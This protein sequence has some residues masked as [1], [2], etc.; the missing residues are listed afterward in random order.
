MKQKEILKQL[1][2]YNTIKDK[3][4]KE[5][6][7][8]IENYLKT[9]NFT[10]KRIKKCLIAYNDKNPK[11]GFIGHTDTV[12]Y[13]SW[14]GNPFE[15]QEK[16]DILIGLGACDMKG[17]IA[18]IL[19]A[20]SKIDLNKNKI[21]LYFTNDEEIAFEGINTIK[22]NIIPNNV[23]IGEP[24]NN[25]P[26][27]GTKGILELEITFY[28]KKCHSST[29]D[30]GI[31]AIYECIDFINK[32]KKYYEKNIKKEIVNDF[33]IPY[34]TM[35]IGIIE[36]GETVN[37]VP[38][39][40]RITIDFRIAKDKTI[41]VLKKKINSLLK[42]YNATVLIKQSIPPRINNSDI[43]FLEKISNKKQT[44]C[45]LTEG[46]YINKDFIILGPGPDTSHQKNEYISCN[47]LKKTEELYIKI[48]EY[49]N[50]GGNYEKDNI[51]S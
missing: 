22:D 48:I 10:T 4:N 9:Y 29:P 1:V 18:S 39:K 3:Q 33:E 49:Y 19:S 7:N 34:T 14:D 35:N 5:I 43:E 25:I 16:E 21:A 15:L 27:Y 11:I 37:S 50:K 2:S 46:S 17:G 40:C 38:G 41:T 32:L 24:T 42:N 51:N 20:I 28:G 26:I 13:E 6:M 31:N 8:Y 44:K 47:S 30:K 12:D 23:I 36:G 45:Y